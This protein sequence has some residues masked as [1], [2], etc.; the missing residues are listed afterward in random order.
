MSEEKKGK[1][2]RRTEV[3]ASQIIG[4]R[5]PMAVAKAI[6]VEAARRQVPLNGLLI[7]MWELYRGAKRGGQ[8]EQA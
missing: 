1:P 3:A 5:L 8:S 2:T 4:F 6:K 7:E